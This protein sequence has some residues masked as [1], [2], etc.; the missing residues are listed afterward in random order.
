[1]LVAIVSCRV[2]LIS[3]NHWWS[4]RLDAW[5]A[6]G[7]NVDGFHSILANEPSLSSEMLMHFES[8][9]NRNKMLNQRIIDSPISQESKAEWLERL[10]DVS[11]TIE[12]V[13]DK[14]LVNIA[15]GVAQP[16][17]TQPS[18]VINVR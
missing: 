2:E 16:S 7:Y 11:Q 6:E 9:I 12:S 14:S 15:I 3:D 18:N 5:S 4:E 1:M 13:V 10:D 17:P 8:L